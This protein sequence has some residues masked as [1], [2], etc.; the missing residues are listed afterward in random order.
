MLLVEMLAPAAL[1][2]DETTLQQKYKKKRRETITDDVN[3][4]DRKWYMFKN[5]ID[6]D[7]EFKIFSL[8][9]T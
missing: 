1:F 6:R 8:T 4:T 5:A 7:N 2:L 3:Y 9:Y